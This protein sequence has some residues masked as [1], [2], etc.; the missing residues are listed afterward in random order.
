MTKK[1]CLLQSMSQEPYII[2]LSLTVHL[3][4]MMI[5]LG[6]LFIFSKF[7][8][9]GL[10]VG[11]RGV[12]GQKMIQNEKNSICHT[13]YL[14][15]HISYDFDLWY[16]MCKMII[17]PGFIFIFSKIWFSGLLGGHKK[18]NK[19]PKWQK[20]LSVPLDISGAIHHMIVICGTQ[21]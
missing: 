18:V 21:V 12:K 14:R 16:F 3:C 10:L 9:F 2:W 17:S 4:K 20:I 15:N 7:W 13:P 11:D 6:V 8:F 1:I 19:S 5:S